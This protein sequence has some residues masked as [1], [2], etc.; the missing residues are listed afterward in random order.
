MR[1]GSRVGIVLRDRARRSRPLRRHEGSPRGRWS[2]RSSTTRLTA[3]AT[4]T[5][6]FFCSKVRAR[7]TRSVSS[8]TPASSSP[9]I[10]MGSGYRAAIKLL[11]TASTITRMV[12]KW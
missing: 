12:A 8:V 1:D 7:S 10:P 4:P 3:Y 9:S 5:R 2:E 11:S 6:R